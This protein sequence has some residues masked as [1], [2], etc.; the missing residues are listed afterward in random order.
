MSYVPDSVITGTTLAPR[1]HEAESPSASKHL[2]FPLTQ[3]DAAVYY[4]SQAGHPLCAFDVAIVDF[5]MLGSVYAY[6]A[7]SKSS[8]LASATREVQQPY[9]LLHSLYPFD[10]M[11]PMSAFRGRGGEDGRMNVARS[12]VT[13]FTP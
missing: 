13:R 1:G 3:E 9:L 4:A 5:E 7:H 10:A 2:V 6:L 8:C 12:R 11:L